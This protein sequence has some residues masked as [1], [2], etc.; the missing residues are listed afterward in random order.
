M[1]SHINFSRRS[2][3]KISLGYTLGA[4]LSMQFPILKAKENQS[5]KKPLIDHIIYLNMAGGM[6]HIDTFDPKPDT[7]V[8]GKF[9]TIDTANGKKISEHLPKLAKIMDR[10]ALIN[11]MTSREGSHERGQ[12]LLHT[13]YPPLGTIIHPTLGSWVSKFTK[14]I[15]EILP[16]FVSIGRNKFSSGYFGSNHESLN[17]VKPELGLANVKLPKNLDQKK[18]ED[19]MSLLNELDSDFQ[20]KYSNLNVTAYNE[21]YQRALKIMFSEDVKVFDIHQESEEIK[22]NYGNTDFGN[23]CLLAR[24]LIER[25]V[26]YVD[27]TLGGWD[28]HENNFERVEELS[29][30]LDT[31]LSNL[32]LELEKKNLYQKTL[33]VLGTEFG[34][35]PQINGRNGRD[36]Y[37][38]AFSCLLAG[39]CI[40]GGTIIGKT[41]ETGESIIENPITMAD[42][43]TTIGV[44]AGLDP[45]KETYS[46]AGRPFKLS[47]NGKIVPEIFKQTNNATSYQ[48]EN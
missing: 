31:G 28:T 15:N 23:G 2:F 21:F 29:K 45:E 9:N 14:P 44:S 6:S 27:L 20:K 19:K 41:N 48:N 39:G 30:T 22:K 7:A 5:S 24:R 1:D 37:P 12:Y 43:Y 32:I 42:L 35:T 25:G 38:K 47:N 18:F 34:R 40:K 3:L 36:H 10:I 16:S 13:N 17:I 11:S 26:R 33:I 8:Q 46:P 4:S